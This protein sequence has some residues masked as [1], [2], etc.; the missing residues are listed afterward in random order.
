MEKNGRTYQQNLVL[1]RLCEGLKTVE[2]ANDKLE[3]RASK[4]VA[5]STGAIAAITGVNMFP[6]SMVDVGRAEAIILALLCGS[7]L[8]M[9]WYAAKL[10]GPQPS[11]VVTS[12]DTKL[13]YEQYIA[14]PEDV[15]FNNALIDSAKAFEHANWVNGIKGQ[16]I[17][18][19]LYVLQAQVILLGS[20]VLLKVFM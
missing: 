12:H 2:Q 16:E 20:G 18:H 8:V 11:A 15:A 13:L 4:I 7:V 14:K 1:E 9:F 3:T 10:W 19:M 6:K 17:R 5:G